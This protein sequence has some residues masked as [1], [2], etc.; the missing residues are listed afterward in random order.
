VQGARLTLLRRRLE[1]LSAQWD[2]RLEAL[3]A[4]VEDD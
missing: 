3:R 1:R 2:A 4:M